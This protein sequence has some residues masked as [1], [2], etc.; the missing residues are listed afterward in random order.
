VRECRGRRGEG[1]KKL[2]GK[3]EIKATDFEC[4]NVHSCSRIAFTHVA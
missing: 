4:G 2:V 3:R 1:V